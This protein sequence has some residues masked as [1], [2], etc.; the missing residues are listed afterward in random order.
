M[1]STS[2]QAAE[3]NGDDY[4]GA[5][6]ETD[7]AHLSKR[8]DESVSVRSDDRVTR[9]FNIYDDISVDEKDMCLFCWQEWRETGLKPSLDESKCLGCDQSLSSA[10]CMGR[11]DYDS[12]YCEYCGGAQ[13][14]AIKQQQ[15]RHPTLE[16][17]SEDEEDHYSPY[18]IHT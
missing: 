18:L 5:G 10:K 2:S 12:F 6:L 9:K 3:V 11:S 15:K 8:D 7:D 4:K 16:I 14:H 13:E 1:L 17:D